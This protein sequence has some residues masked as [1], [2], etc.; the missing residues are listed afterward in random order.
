MKQMRR[1]ISEQLRNGQTESARIRVESVIRDEKLL[2]AYNILDLYLELF[3]VRSQLISKT[4]E[5]PRD[6]TEA[7][8]SVIY[9]ARRIS[10]VPELTDLA[11]MFAAKYGKEFAHEAGA[12]APTCNKWSVNSNIVRCLLAPKQNPLWVDDAQA[13]EQDPRAAAQAAALA[14]Q[15]AQQMMEHAAALAQQQGA[16]VPM[17]SAQP[18][19][20]GWM[21]QHVPQ[22]AA[23]GPSSDPQAWQ[24]QLQVPPGL[25]QPQQPQAQPGYVVRSAEDI[26]RAYDAAVGPPQKGALAP[27][28]NGPSGPPAAAAAPPSVPSNFA[29]TNAGNDK[30]PSAPAAPNEDDEVFASLTRRLENLKSG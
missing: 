18:P 12:D 30:V 8:A 28:H 25:H 19:P 10:D 17:A 13:A 6:L 16:Y 14:A 11:K 23:A 5:I 1:Q 24:P 2:Q 4:K 7:V 29:A 15:R 21:Q 26:Q 27:P 9:A 20:M 3:T 22:P